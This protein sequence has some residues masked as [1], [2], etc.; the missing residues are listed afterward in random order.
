MKVRIFTGFVIGVVLCLSLLFVPH[1]IIA[2]AFVLIGLIA[3]YELI[4][5]LT[6]NYSSQANSFCWT[7]FIMIAF[8]AA[9]VILSV[10]NFTMGY[11]VILCA[12]V[13]V[14]GFTAG[15]IAGKKSHKVSFLKTV[16]PNKS[17]EGYI[18]SIICCVVFGYLLYLPLKQYLPENIY[19]FSFF[20]WAPAIA[21]D[22]FE[23]KI[24]RMLK[25]SDSGE[26]ASKYGGKFIKA[27][28]KP[29]SSH[30]GYLDRIDSFVFAIVAYQVF[31]TIMP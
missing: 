27:L 16:S 2:A 3:I 20:A 29:I 22:L 21:G 24:K 8:A 6:H 5:S 7:E 26:C 25:V 1:M 19:I 10:N 30:G 12:L 14:G 4:S 31:L 15:K 13:D 28:E 23:S 18:C 11:I 9:A 17:W